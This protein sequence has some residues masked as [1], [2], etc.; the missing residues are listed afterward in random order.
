[1]MQNPS[2]KKD[3]KTRT[4]YLQ[5]SYKNIFGMD[6]N[7]QQFALPIYYSFLDCTSSSDIQFVL[8][9]DEDSLLNAIT[10]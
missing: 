7:E 2:A 3:E 8:N 5:P 1:M 10:S 9:I 6:F 4:T